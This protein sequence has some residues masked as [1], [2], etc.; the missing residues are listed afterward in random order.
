MIEKDTRL[1]SLFIVLQT[2]GFIST[3][4]MLST[5]QSNSSAN[6]LRSLFDQKALPASTK[7]KG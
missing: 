7:L 4:L 6:P 1:T 5:R 3:S 2:N